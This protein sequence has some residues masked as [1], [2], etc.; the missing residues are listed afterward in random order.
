MVFPLTF[1]TAAS[2][3]ALRQYA[4]NA[5]PLG[6]PWKSLG[7]VRSHTNPASEHASRISASVARNARF[8]TM[9][10]QFFGLAPSHPPRARAHRSGAS[11]T[12]SGPAPPTPR[13]FARATA[14]TPPS[15][16]C[17]L[18]RR[19]L[20]LPTPGAR[21]CSASTAIWAAAADSKRTSAT[22]R[23][24]PSWRSF[25]AFTTSGGAGET[26]SST[27]P[28]ASAAA[29]AASA[30]TPAGS[31]A[32][33]SPASATVRDAASSASAGCA[34]SAGA[35]R[36]GRR[37]GTPPRPASEGGGLKRVL[38]ASLSL[39][40]PA[41][42]SAAA[43]AAGRASEA[44]APARCDGFCFATSIV[45][46]RPSTLNDLLC[47]TAAAAS[48]A[49]ANCTNPNPLLFPPA[50]FLSAMMKHSFTGPISPNASS[51]PASVHEYGRL[52]TNT[53]V[54]APIAETKRDT[55]AATPPRVPRPS[56]CAN[57]AGTRRR[58]LFLL[59][60]AA[61]GRG[62]KKELDRNDRSL[63]R[64]PVGES[65]RVVPPDVTA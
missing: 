35:P 17:A 54:G 40:S 30:S 11:F 46:A 5:N 65:A 24:A 13:L 45:T 26:M 50:P 27:E 3:C 58:A 20:R 28:S 19:P 52:R 63:N 56:L 4:A 44:P 12:L 47:A 33:R 55:H 14:S 32:R 22:P 1:F 57:R 37:E 41:S 39:S 49:S 16:N 18:M 29:N 7:T 62:K 59:G 53:V 36:G 31:P 61:D 8:R 60:A 15:S 43:A 9:T 23:V 38:G 48:S 2:A 6:F 25:A 10:R 64:Q 51:K 42:A 21:R 34:G